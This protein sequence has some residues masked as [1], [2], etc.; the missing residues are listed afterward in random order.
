MV[1]SWE[2][3]LVKCYEGSDI[4][5]II[6][7]YYDGLYIEILLVANRDGWDLK[8]LLYRLMTIPTP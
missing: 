5:V 2:T 3:T 6:L 8:R 4:K 7:D 1:Y